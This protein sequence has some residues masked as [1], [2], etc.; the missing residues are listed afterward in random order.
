[1]VN[2]DG[3]LIP[4]EVASDG[5]VTVLWTLDQVNGPQ[6]QTLRWG[7]SGGARDQ[8][9]GAVSGPDGQGQYSASFLAPTGPVTL[10]VEV[11][12]SD[13]GDVLNSGVYQVSILAPVPSNTAPLAVADAYSLDQDTTLTVA[14]AG[15]LANDSDADGD[16]LSALLVTDV[17]N[18]SLSLSADGSF[19]YTPSAGFVGSDSF[20]YVADDGSAQSAQVV[21]S[22]SVNAVSGDPS[23]LLHYLLD[24]TSGSTAVD[25]SG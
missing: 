20:I 13:S 8:L 1:M 22:L 17:S 9:G 24:E 19:S 23:L 18:G 11:E 12:I 6:T 7:V 2:Q 10:D 25:S 4:A 3:S 21:V 15:V 14:A 5:V 16:A